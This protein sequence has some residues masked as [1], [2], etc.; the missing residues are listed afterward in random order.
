MIKILV[1]M[2][3]LSAL[4]FASGEAVSEGGTDIVQR[5]V[6]FLI[7]I[8]ILYYL[9]AEPIK[10]FFVGRTDGIADELKKVRDKLQESKKAKEDAQNAIDEANKFAESLKESS[11]KENN[12]LND[13][14][15]AQCESDLENM[16]KQNIALMEFEQ[17][18]M[19]RK[20]VENIVSDMLKEDTLSKDA[21]TD[22][23]IKKVA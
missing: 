11:K 6:N 7:F 9:L 4:A 8:G 19:T 13:K 3:S 23:I 10:S 16:Q 17:R 22:L 2:L 20:V 15:M 5:T 1:T 14:I 21:M 18:A 12:I